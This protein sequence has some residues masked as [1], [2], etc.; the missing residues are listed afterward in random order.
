MN[1]FIFHQQRVGK[2]GKNFTI[3]KVRTMYPHANI[4]PQLLGIWIKDPYNP[5]VIPGLAWMRKTWVDEL[6]QIV[7]IILW[8][9]N[10]FWSRAIVPEIYR[11]LKEW[12]KERYIKNK[13]WIF[14]AYI[15]DGANMI[16]NNDAYLRLRYKKEKEWPLA[17]TLMNM[18]ALRKSI[19]KILQWK[20]L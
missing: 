10:F 4:D 14:W 18:E 20:H 7:N 13:P 6:P 5:Y 8:D 3:H 19:I 12:K 9:M 1:S 11:A 2:W 16:R 15:F 17:V